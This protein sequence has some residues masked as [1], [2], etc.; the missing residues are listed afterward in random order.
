MIQRV[1]VDLVSLV[2][3]HERALEWECGENS[4][5]PQDP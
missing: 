4:A 2:R 3:Q 5:D 1:A